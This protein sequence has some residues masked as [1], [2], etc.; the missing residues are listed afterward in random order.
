MQCKTICLYGEAVTDSDWS[1]TDITRPFSVLLYIL[2]GSAFYT[3][4]GVETPLKKGHLYLLPANC[5]YSLRE[6]PQDKLNRLY[7]HVFT[8]PEINCLIDVDVYGDTFVA[9]TL[10]SIR[11]F[12]GC[13]DSY[14]YVYHLTNMLLSYV[15]ET[16]T[17]GKLP[18]HTRVHNYIDRHYIQIFQ[19]D[20]LEE[21]FNYSASHISKVFRQEY[22]LTPKQYAKKLLLEEI[23]AMMQQ[24]LSVTQIA[25]HLEFSSPGNLSRFFKENCGCSPKE[26][27]KTLDA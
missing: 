17:E 14:L 8:T 26:Y 27:L 6:D 13:E 9:Q 10:S 5:T 2:G 24:G 3:I 18:L 19:R 15:C 11:A 23:I 16:V 4:D 21:R 12:I 1:Y 20:D 25:E 22:G 7:V